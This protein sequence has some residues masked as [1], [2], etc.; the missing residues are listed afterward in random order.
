MA[1]PPPSNP[2][3]P[4]I[5]LVSP[6][7]QADFLPLGHQGISCVRRCYLQK[8]FFPFLINSVQFHSHICTFVHP[9]TS[10]HQ[11]SLCIINSQRMLQLMSIKSVMPSNHLILCPP[12]LLLPSIF[13]SF[14]VFPI[15]QF[16]ASG[17][18]S[19]GASA[20]ASVLSMNIQ[21]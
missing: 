1:F 3:N 13:P 20:S 18:Q 11:T 21:D 6:A 15:S 16:F 12:L 8:R 5:E 2:S 4:G 9:L 10:A 7:L 14:K 19:I 17:G